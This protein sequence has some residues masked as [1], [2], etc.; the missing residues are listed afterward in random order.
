MAPEKLPRIAVVNSDRCKPKKCRQ[1]CKRGCPVVMAGNTPFSL[2]FPIIEILSV[3]SRV[4]SEVRYVLDV[5]LH[6]RI[7][8][9]PYGYLL[10]HRPIWV[11]YWPIY[12]CI[13]KPLCSSIPRLETLVLNWF[14]VRK[15]CKKKTAFSWCSPFLH[16]FRYSTLY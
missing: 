7:S 1:E 8:D 6:K 13:I 3:L 4:L 14:L 9:L 10:T 15:L 12:G 11:W 16:L 2:W 5:P